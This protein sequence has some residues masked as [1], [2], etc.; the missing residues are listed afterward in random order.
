ETDRSGLGLY[1][2]K[3]IIEKHGGTVTIESKE[4]EGT[5]VVVG[6]ILL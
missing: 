6:F 2:T 3:T 5:K 4:G 1:I